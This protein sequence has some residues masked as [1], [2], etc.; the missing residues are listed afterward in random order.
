MIRPHFRF[1]IASVVAALAG[2]NG[3]MGLGGSSEYAC[4]VAPGVTCES[5]SNVYRMSREGKLPSKSSPPA[6][7]A[8]STDADPATPAPARA[9]SVT[10]T[11]PIAAAAVPSRAA[12]VSPMPIRSQPR[13]LRGWIVPYE[14]ADGDLVGDAYVFIPVDSG[15]WMVE[16]ARQRIREQ[17]APA[18]PT[19][20]AV[21]APTTTASAT[22]QSGSTTSSTSSVGMPP[23]DGAGADLAT[24]TSAVKG[25][26]GQSAPP[27]GSVK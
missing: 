24:F 23:P 19:A 20:A 12:M 7:S 13:I 22:T 21:A 5:V 17:Y 1:V 18:R 4:P 8:P 16:H 10:A 3:T 26:A 27:S 6:S 9:T 2:C 14:D 11:A 25:V 15:R